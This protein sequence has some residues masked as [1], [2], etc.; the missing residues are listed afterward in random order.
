MDIGHA[1][2]V[3]YKLDQIGKYRICPNKY[4]IRFFKA[5]LEHIKID[6]V[7]GHKAVLNKFHVNRQ[8]SCKSSHTEYSLILVQMKMEVSIGKQF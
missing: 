2:N 8:V 1:T 5:H 4:R 7:L 6:H 3:I